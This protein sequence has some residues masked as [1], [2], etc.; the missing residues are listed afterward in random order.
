MSC[1]RHPVEVLQQ[2]PNPK[3]TRLEQSEPPPLPWWQARRRREPITNPDLCFVCQRNDR[4]DRILIRQPEPSTNQVNSVLNYFRKSDSGMAR[5]GQP[6][7]ASQEKRSVPPS[8]H[9]QPPTVALSPCRYCERSIC[10]GCIVQCPNCQHDFCI[11]CW[12]PQGN[13]AVCVECQWSPHESPTSN[14]GV[15]DFM[16]VD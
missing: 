3:K 9:C 8:P 2:G 12:G 11:L 10:R 7:I 6:T 14:G 1:K 13:D 5:C 4:C 16:H 15:D